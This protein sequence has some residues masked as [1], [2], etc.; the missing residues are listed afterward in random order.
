MKKPLITYMSALIIFTALTATFMSWR[1]QNS[2]LPME[3]AMEDREIIKMDLNTV[4][5]DQLQMIPGVG[6]TLSGRVI[7]Y[8]EIN[9]PFQHVEDVLNIK[10]IG[11]V[12]LEEFLTYTTVGE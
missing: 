5:T 7:E 4:T 8:R 6:P 11:P 10:G 1:S 3:A 12:L 2:I 9:G